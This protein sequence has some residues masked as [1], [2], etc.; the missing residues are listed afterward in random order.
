MPPEEFFKSLDPDPIGLFLGRHLLQACFPCFSGQRWLSNPEHWVRDSALSAPRATSRPG[1]ALSLRK[2]E[3][4][5]CAFTRGE[6]KLSPLAGHALFDVAQVLV[7]ILFRYTNGLREIHCR[8]G[9]L[10]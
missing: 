8:H 9:V 10:P 5:S 6:S 3:S 4:A 2:L 7:D 1:K